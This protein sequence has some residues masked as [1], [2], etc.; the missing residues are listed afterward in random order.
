MVNVGEY[1]GGPRLPDATHSWSD[2]PV[3]DR[4]GRVVGRLVPDT[5]TAGPEAGLATLELTPQARSRLEID[6]D[7]IP[8]PHREI[9]AI[10][11]DGVRLATPLRR[12]RARQG[13]F[14]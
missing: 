6:A 2:K 13:G 8:V 9:A 11:R 14:R 4:D 12:L 3:C 1:H 7:A 5:S 10:R